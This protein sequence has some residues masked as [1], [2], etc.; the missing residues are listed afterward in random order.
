MDRTSSRSGPCKTT[1]ARE[2]TSPLKSSTVPVIVPGCASGAESCWATVMVAVQMYKKS[3]RTD[4]EIGGGIMG[5]SYKPVGFLTESP[6]VLNLRI[7][8]MRRRF[9]RRWSCKPCAKIHCVSNLRKVSPLRH[10]PS[11]RAISSPRLVRGRS[12]DKWGQTPESFHRNRK[13][14]DLAYKP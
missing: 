6:A 8:R 3:A 7:D 11:R 13:S 9:L 14:S 4:L 2:T 5:S 10:S 12:V 1:V